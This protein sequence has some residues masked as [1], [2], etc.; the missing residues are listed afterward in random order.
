MQYLI[1]EGARHI[2]LH[3]D[4]HIHSALSPCAQDDMTPNNIVNM[5]KLNGLDIIAVTDHNSALSCRAVCK[6]GE[7]AGLIVVPGMELTTAEEIH[8]LCLFGD[9]RSAEQFNVYVDKLL[10]DFKNKPEIFG[11]QIVYDENDIPVGFE[12]KLLINA[13]RI[14]LDDVAMCVQF[15]G[16]IAVLAHIDRESNG[17]LSILGTVEPHMGFTLAEL[18]EYACV[19]EYENRFEF[20]RIIQNSDAH[21]LWQIAEPNQNNIIFGDIKTAKDFILSITQISKDYCIE[22]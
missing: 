22:I 2:R 4:L 5:A 17:I 11:N 6:A 20:L 15:Y 12:E 16:G 7:H 13:T 10:P 3:Y 14:Q 19:E 1:R 21:A 9:V 18:S 8:V